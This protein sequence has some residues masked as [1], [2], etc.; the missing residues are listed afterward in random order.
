M[1]LKSI[2]NNFI[3]KLLIVPCLLALASCQHEK[4]VDESE[5]KAAFVLNDSV[6]NIIKIDTVKSHILEGGLD[7]NGE[8]TFDENKVV[9]VM[10]LVTGTV[11]DVNI[12]LGDY[13]TQGQTLATIKSSELANLQSQ[14]SAATADLN[15]AKKNLEV[16]K[17]LAQKG[18]NSEK[19]VMQTQ[20]EVNKDEASVA[21]LNKQLS[22][23]GGGE[24]GSQ[25][26]IK[27]PVNGYIVKRSINPNQV[28]DANN[29][30]PL[31]IVSD[32][33]QVWVMA[34]VYEADIEKIKSGEDVNITTIAYPDQVFKGK[35]SYI[36]NVLDPE[37]KTMK[38]RV[39]LDNP[40]N[41]LKPDMFAKVSLTY[42]DNIEVAAI[43]KDAV[44]FDE[45]RNFVVVYEGRDKLSVRH[46]D[47]YPPGKDLLY[48]RNGLKP[49]ERII[50]KN[51]L[52]IYNALTSL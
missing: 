33:K 42:K 23:I 18:I 9:R 39:V 22:I 4:K 48:V 16:S 17:D 6:A 49:G 13:V 27:S 15:I 26:Q 14:L 11:A 28:I 41:L 7:L 34:N 46:I 10:P 1:K 30:D 24:S 29:N 3:S 44:V 12:E 38:I 21:N 47:L 31:F 19:E 36:S 45:S 51:Q 32:L 25:V 35:I 50:G 2:K 43:P 37:N 52:I 5:V 8:I 20:Q 40:N